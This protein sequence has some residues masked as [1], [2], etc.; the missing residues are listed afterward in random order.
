[1]RGKPKAFQEHEITEWAEKA[2]EWKAK[3]FCHARK[4]GGGDVYASLPQAIN[5]AIDGIGS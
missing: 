3:Q 2:V 1:V 5:S 4:G